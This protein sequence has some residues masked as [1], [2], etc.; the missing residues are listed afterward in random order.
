[1]KS[2]GTSTFKVLA[3]PPGRALPFR[4]L[5]GARACLSFLMTPGLGWAGITVPNL[6]T[7]SLSPGQ[8]RDGGRAAGCP[9]PV[10]LQAEGSLRAPISPARVLTGD[11]PL[12]TSPFAA[13]L[14]IPEL[15]VCGALVVTWKELGAPHPGVSVQLLAAC[16]RTCELGWGKAGQCGGDCGKL[17]STLLA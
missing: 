9:R 14:P 10:L 7:G 16:R 8:S 15:S 1:M 13:P 11:V 12:P 4:S 2:F 3:K 17:E 6:E 5:P